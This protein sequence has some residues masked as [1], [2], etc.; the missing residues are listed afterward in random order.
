MEQNQICETEW[1][2]ERNPQWETE[3]ETERNPKWETGR[4]PEEGTGNGDRKLG[5]ESQ[6]RTGLGI[7]D[8]NEEI[9]ISNANG[10]QMKTLHR[11]QGETLH[12]KQREILHGKEIKIQA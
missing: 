2:T 6:L 11:K 4:V 8:A 12:G 9:G 7:A 1:E 3:L 10:K 5:S